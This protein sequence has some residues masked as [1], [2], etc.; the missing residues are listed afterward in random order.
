MSHIQ[1]HLHGLPAHFREPLPSYAHCPHEKPLLGETIPQCFQRI[2]TATPEKEALVSIKQNRRFSYGELDRIVDQAA[3]SF[4]RLGIRKGDRVAIWS[5]NNYEWWVT[6]FATAKIGAI[7]VNINPAYR[8]HELEYV[9]KE[10]RAKALCLIE[11]FKASNYVEMFYQI[12]PEARQAEPGQIDSWRFPHLKDVIMIGKERHPGMFTRREFM[13]IG[14]QESDRAS[15]PDDGALDIDDVINIQ[16]TSGTTGFP[17]GVLLT[18]HNILN[19]AYFTALEMG[20]GPEDRLC[21]P[22][23]FYHCFGMVLSNLVTLVSGATLVI[24]APLFDPEATLAAVQQERCTILH[25]VPT[26]FIAELEHPSFKNYDLSSL[27][28]GIMAGALCPIDTMRKVNALMH[29]EQV[30][31]GY[32]QTECSPIATLTRPD[33]ALEKRVSTVGTVAP[34]EELKVVDPAT[35]RTVPRGRQGEICLRGY[36]VMRGY[37]NNP[38]AT[39]DAIDPQGWL[40]SGD[41]GVMEEDGYVKITGR[42][43]EMVIRGGENLFPREV[44]EF[45]RGIASVYDVYVVGVPDKKYGEELLACIKLKPG[46]PAPTEAEWREM[47]KGKIAHVKIPRYW[48]TVDEFPMTV[49]GKIQKFKLAEWGANQLGLG[50]LSAT[51]RGHNLPYAE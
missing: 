22:V 41:L 38:E 37:D 29:M 27:R 47:C 34:H 40:H 2:A 32:G 7:L 16:Y 1:D 30:V 31:I 44:E 3:G 36:H 43:K 15:D 25:G 49:T 4:Y 5:T 18:H 11:S 51:E 42:L 14:P 35:G 28:G 13:E 39:A 12:C 20:M 48:L 6:Q 46:V 45:L 26:M 24:P 19:N 21:V 33:A 23:P 8:T 50:A 9:L 10:S 17:K